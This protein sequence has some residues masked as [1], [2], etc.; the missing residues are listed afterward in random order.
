MQP[1][2]RQLDLFDLPLGS[3]ENAALWT[4]REV[5]IRL[6]QRVMA[7]LG[8]DRRIDYKRVD[9]PRAERIDFNEIAKYYSAYSNTPDGGVLVFGATSDG[10]ATGCSSVPLAQLNRLEKCHLTLCPLAC[11]ANATLYLYKVY[12]NHSW[13]DES[14]VTKTSNCMCVLEVHSSSFYSPFSCFCDCQRWK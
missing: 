8:E 10:I 5:W 4:P 1:G 14:L 7:Q 13:R 12:I 9:Y 2:G 3:G 11:A 6:S